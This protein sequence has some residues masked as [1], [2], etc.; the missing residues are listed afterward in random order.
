MNIPS[1]LLTAKA[2]HSSWDSQSD[3]CLQR[4]RCIV[5]AFANLHV[6]SQR[7]VAKMQQNVFERGDDDMFYRIATFYSVLLLLC[8][9]PAY[10]D[11]KPATPAAITR[12]A[13]CRAIS[14]DPARLACFDREVMAFDTAV[15]E[16]RVAVVDQADIRKTRRTLFGIAVPSIALFDKTGEPEPKEV[17]AQ[18]TSTRQGEGGRILFTLE[19]GAVWA[20]T[21]DYPVFFSVKPGQ[22]VTLKR[23]ALGSYFADFEKAVTVRAKRIR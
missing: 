19:D 15:R 17:V 11:E 1:L 12:L 4:G 10:A 13:A 20:Q 6:A 3:E 16:H 9:R 2:S 7:S 14:D 18:I 8:S 21:D 23:A 5:N 22:K